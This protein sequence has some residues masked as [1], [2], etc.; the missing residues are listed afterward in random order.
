MPSKQDPF[1]ELDLIKPVSMDEACR[2]WQ[3]A[4][5]KVAHCESIKKFIQRQASDVDKAIR[6]AG[7][8][9]LPRAKQKLEEAQEQ[10]M[11]ALLL[12]KRSA[13]H[14]QVNWID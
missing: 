6:D 13:S 11:E 4:E 1:G 7:N 3:V 12:L 8:A 9:L 14:Y 5:A 10:Q 2:I